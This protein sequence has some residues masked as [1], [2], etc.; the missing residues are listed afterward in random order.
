MVS[1]PTQ[2]ESRF[3]PRHPIRILKGS[4]ER[5]YGPGFDG[6]RE[7]LLKMNRAQ[8]ISG[9]APYLGVRVSEGGNQRHHFARKLGRVRAPTVVRIELRQSPGC[10]SA[11]ACIRVLECS[12]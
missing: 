3:A 1:K 9:V 2:S 10:A 12:K 4:D 8:C 5:F 6:I 11:Y 7:T